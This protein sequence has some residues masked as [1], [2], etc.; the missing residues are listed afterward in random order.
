MCGVGG[1]WGKRPLD[2]PGSLARGFA[3]ALAHRGPDG[4]GALALPADPARQLGA[5]SPESLDGLGPLQGFL[6]HRR[7]SILDLATGDQPMSDAAARAWI[8]FN[9][10]IYNYLELRRELE[11]LPGVVFRTR[12]DTEVILQVYLNWGMQGFSRLNGIFGFGLFD[13]AKRRL[14]LARDP[15]GVKPLYW[16]ARNGSVAFASEIAPL[17]A[18]GM[19]GQTISPERLAQFLFYRFVPSPGTLWQ[20][21]QKVVPGSALEFDADGRVTNEVDFASAPAATRPLGGDWADQL[22]HEFR[23]AVSRQM[24][25]DVPVGAFLS[26]G[27]D[28]SLVVAAMGRD[29][30]APLTF[31]IGFPGTADSPSELLASRLAATTLGA[32]HE[33]LEVDTTDYIARFPGIVAMVEEPLAEAGML[34]LSDLAAFAKRRVKVVLTGQG[35]DEPLGGYPRHQA[36]R[37]ALMLRPLLG[38]AGRGDGTG[39]RE[40]LERFLRI[41]AA[42][43]SG[44]AAA[45][46]SALTPEQ[47]GSL[48]RNCGAERGAGA[49]REGVERWWRKSEGMDDLARILYVDVR[50]SLADDLLLMGDKTSMAHGLEARVPFLDLEY[51]CRVEAIPGAERVPLWR[52]RKWI[53]HEL[54]RR[55]LPAKLERALAGSPN[56]FRKKRGFEVPVDRWLRERLG[57]SLATR[58]TGAG[59]MLPELVDRRFVESAVG[60]YLQGRRRAYRTVFALYVLEEWLRSQ[61]AR[62]PLSGRSAA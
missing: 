12:S 54:A 57:S 24:L 27:L 49:V 41:A 25:A 39:R 28:S 31:G 52:R 37:L 20:D 32:E 10:E 8:V 7:L 15:A 44:L 43:D 1:L 40:K 17:R 36:A 60:E 11:Q 33:G 30:G 56:P 23:S 48:V 51:L 47:A 62:V 26:G 61:F 59:S 29:Q 35:A 16:C 19:A 38:R 34:L 5:G 9:G 3:A 46:F 4:E 45:P 53:Q 22:A 6:V 18:G 58:L 14:V 21:I 42:K 55:I 2:H 50:T 13:V